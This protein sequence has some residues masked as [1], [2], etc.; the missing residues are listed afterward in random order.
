MLGGSFWIALLRNA[1]GAALILGIFL[2]L[3][4]PRFPMKK[5]LGYYGV[6]GRL[7]SGLTVFG[8][9]SMLRCLYAFRD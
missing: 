8:T 2:L 6:F 7:P 5:M 9:W 4:R 3:D 1:M